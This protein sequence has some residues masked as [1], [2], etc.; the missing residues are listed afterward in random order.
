MQL[1][2]LIYRT[3]SIYID[4][5]CHKLPTYVDQGVSKQ[6]YWIQNQKQPLKR[7]RQAEICIVNEAALEYKI[8]NLAPLIITKIIYIYRSN[9]YVLVDQVTDN[10]KGQIKPKAD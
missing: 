4:G 1:Y 5:L 2:M 10:A 3:I 7:G 6:Q 9:N 8:E